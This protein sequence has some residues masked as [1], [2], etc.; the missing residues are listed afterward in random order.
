MMSFHVDDIFMARNPKTKKDVK[1]NI[2]EN[3][4][5]S[6]SG[7]VKKFLGFYYKRGHYAK[8]TYARTTT[9]KDLKKLV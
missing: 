3:F 2:K 9:E 8:C 5:I 1:E 7:K 4:N 6:D